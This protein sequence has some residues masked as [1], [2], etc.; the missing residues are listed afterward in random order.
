MLLSVGIIVS[1]K[2]HIYIVAKMAKI[3]HQ[4]MFIC[5]FL[6]PLPPVSWEA[7]W[8]WPVLFYCST[9]ATGESSLTVSF[10]HDTAMVPSTAKSATVMIV[11]FIFVVFYCFLLYL[12]DNQLLPFAA[13]CL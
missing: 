4:L 5:E 7:W 6:T 9:A 13:Q 12:N 10:W 3:C 11:L 2:M 1:K 8:R